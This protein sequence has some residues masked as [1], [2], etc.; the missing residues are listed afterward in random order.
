MN[1]TIFDDNL[2]HSTR[3]L[4]GP[5]S[6]EGEDGS[7]PYPEPASEDQLHPPP[8]FKPFFTLIED[9]VTG[10]HYHPKVHYVFSDDDADVLTSAALDALESTDASPDEAEERIVIIDMTPDGKNFASAVS[11]SPNWQAIKTTM[12]QAPSWGSDA[13]DADRGLMLK[14][15]GQEAATGQVK[16]LQQAASL[17]ELVRGFGERLD[18]LDDVLRGKNDDNGATNDPNELHASMEKVEKKEE[19]VQ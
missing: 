1:V 10:E 16:R 13:A 11:L 3:P 5:A 7:F 18:G 8:D 15:S 6:E 2:F 4:P 9:P 12:R 17:E 14:I 19:A